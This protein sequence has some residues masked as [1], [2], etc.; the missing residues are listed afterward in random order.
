MN[1]LDLREGSELIVT[2]G[3]DC[4]QKAVV[5]GRHP[6]G[7]YKVSVRRAEDKGGVDSIRYLGLWWVDAASSGEVP[8]I[9]LVTA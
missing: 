2:T 3:A 7:H 9:P 4:G 5:L 1:V 6:E 8:C